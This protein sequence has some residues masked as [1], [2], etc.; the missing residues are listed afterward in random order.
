[1]AMMSPHK[2]RAARESAADDV[3]VGISIQRRGPRR[4]AGEQPPTADLGHRERQ[5]PAM[6][7]GGG[8]GNNN[9]DSLLLG[10]CARRAAI[11]QQS[12]SLDHLVR[13]R[14]LSTR[15]SNGARLLA[16][17]RGNRPKPG[18]PLVVHSGSA[19]QDNWIQSQPE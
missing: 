9:R 16:E 3:S 4:P 14:N 8:N 17:H 6:E 19:G 18:L 1:M 5:R 10:G 12:A 11:A 2:R 15:P 7:L 13:R